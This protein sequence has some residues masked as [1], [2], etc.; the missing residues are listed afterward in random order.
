MVAINNMFRLATFLTGFASL[1]ASAALPEVHK[2]DTTDGAPDLVAR[3]GMFDASTWEEYHRI[4]GQVLAPNGWCMSYLDPTD[5][6]G[7]WACGEYCPNSDTKVCFAKAGSADREEWINRNPNGERWVMGECQC[8]S[9]ANTI[10]TVLVDFTGK[11][12]DEGFRHLGKVSCELT[13]NVL[14]E[15]AFL[16]ASFIPGAGQVAIAARTTAQAVK[17]ASKTRG[18]KD[19]WTRTVEGTCGAFENHDDIDKGYNNLLTREDLAAEATEEN[20]E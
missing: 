4:N 17:L 3:A 8:D 20:V 12:L 9:A 16:G 18:G 19:I 15:A 13:L 1:A 14:K 2:K 11:G 6:Q 5:R 7:N 10:A